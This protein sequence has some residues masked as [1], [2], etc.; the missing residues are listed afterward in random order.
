M[1]YFE[2]FSRK[3]GSSLEVA[4]EL[5]KLAERF[6][7]TP[8]QLAQDE[9]PEIESQERFGGPKLETAY[10]EDSEGKRLLFYGDGH[11]LIFPFLNEA[12]KRGVVQLPLR[13]VLNLDYHADIATYTEHT[14]C[15]TASWQRYGVDK[16]FWSSSGSYNWQPKHSTAV[17]RRDF[18][19]EQFIKSIGADQSAVL[20]P[21]LLSIDIDFFNN[22]DPK[23]PEFSE[24]LN[25]LKDIIR[26]SKCIFVFSSSGFTDG[27][28]KP[29]TLRNVVE[30]IQNTF[31]K[32][33]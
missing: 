28:V 9:F 4:V 18:N 32:K 11:G 20:E 5:Q 8:R 22:L 1:E 26:K 14:V 23:S 30:E 25:I 33:D 16:G 24:Y 15:H 27:K 10:L 6:P 31:L 29:E 13:Q 17:P 21:D 2:N 3:F 12:V 19:P 7:I